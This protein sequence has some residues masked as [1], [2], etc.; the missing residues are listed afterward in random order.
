MRV[1]PFDGR[2]LYP[3]ARGGESVSGGSP[4]RPRSSGKLLAVEPQS[5]DI[6]GAR[7][8]NL[9]G[10]TCSVPKKK[11]VVFTGPS[12]SGKSSLAIDTVFAEGRRR[13]VESL[14]A[15]ARQFLG[16]KEKPKFDHISGLSP[17]IAVEQKAASTN[18]RSTVGTITEIADYLRVLFARLGVQHCPK[19]GRTVEKQSAQQV[20]SSILA[21]PE[22]T[23]VVLLAPRVLGRKGEHKEEL[24][25]LRKKGLVRARVNGSM[26]TLDQVPALDKKKKHTIEAVVDRIVVK[27]SEKARITYSV[28][29]TLRLGEGKLTLHFPD[30][31][32][33]A[34]PHGGGRIAP[35][36]SSGSD[37]LLSER[38]ACE[39]CEVSFPDLTPQSFS[40]NSPQGLCVACNGL[41]FTLEMDPEL[42]VPDPEKTIDQ[43][44]I[45]LWNKGSEDN[46]NR[47]TYRFLMAVAKAHKVDVHRPWKDLPEKHRN[48][49]LHGS[50]EPVTV[51]WSGKKSQGSYQASWEGVLPN[52]KRRLLET[53]SEDMKRFYLG[54]HSHR[55][56][57]DCEGARLRIESRHVRVAGTTI[58]AINDLNVREA[59]RFFDELPQKLA[60]VQR[61]ISEALLKEIRARLR[62][63]ENVGLDYLSLGRSGPTLSGGE[64]QRIQL[65]SQIGSELS[66]V[67][68]VL[69][70]PSIGLHARDASKLLS[71][72]EH[73]RDLGNTVVVVEHDRETIERADWILDF[74][75]GAG[76]EGGE[77]TA[78]GTPEE[79][80]ANPRS[81]TGQYLSGEKTIPV[82]RERRRVDPKKA[83]TVRGARA[84]NLRGIDVSFPLGVFTCVTGVSGAGKS[85]LVNHI[86]LP[87]LERKLMGAQSQAGPHDK[88]VGVDLLDKVIAIDQ[89]P[90]GR[91]PRSNPATYVK[92][93]DPIREFYAQLPES[94]AYG[95]DAGRFSFNVKGGRCEG[96]EGSGVKKIEMHFLADVYVTCEE[97][98]G[99]RFNDATLRVAYRGKSIADILDMTVREALDLFRTHKHVA[100]LL[101][102][103]D[104][105]GLGYVALGQQSPT[106]SGG[107]AQRVKLAKELGRTATGRTLYVLDEPSTGLHFDDINKLLLVLSRL[108]DK[109]NT[110]V[111]IEHNLDI[112]KTADWVIDIGPEGGGEGGLLVAE[113]TPEDV[114]RESASHTGRFLKK[115]LSSDG[116]SMQVCSGKNGKRSPARRS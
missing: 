45:A 85:T 67:V 37:R 21:L 1:L 98:Q 5:I 48:V 15:Y 11:F 13:F 104:E 29:S 31:A 18:P 24:D 46:Q 108:V 71:T 4:P 61:K 106:L 57:P 22:G 114:A 74:G 103:L 73:L 62:F 115:V 102:T 66:G 69:D 112:V 9:K 14:S 110:V 116:R 100:K 91:T 26:V 84:N 82:P 79:I 43:G 16:Q 20:V 56:C 90:I 7:E 89:Q 17:C 8:H 6:S 47:W 83:V 40:S 81:L 60:P 12:G 55:P 19:C 35:V 25:D 86:L 107:E 113:G 30:T 23:K 64:S 41:G 63:L 2:A 10:V 3:R 36:Q 44:A 111:V 94:K 87:A 93:F 54:F 27:A 96:C 95:F 34:P 109:G 70:E 39:E 72:L 78:T 68:Y 58:A 76:R 32:G 49:I 105:V 88:I 97:C 59:A 52:I 75:P 42:V 101:E 38:L 51:E 92:V 53:Q 28:E 50:E 65:A 80:A 33:G 99:K 77:V